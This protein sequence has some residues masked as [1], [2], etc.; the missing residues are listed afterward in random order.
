MAAVRETANQ[1]KNNLLKKM[2]DLDEFFLEFIS[3]GKVE[4]SQGTLSP[5]KRDPHVTWSKRTKDQEGTVTF[6]DRLSLSWLAVPVKNVKSI[7]SMQTVMTNT[8][9]PL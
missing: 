2:R 5:G 6:W 8:L 7:R 9:R 3:N 4:L 1:R